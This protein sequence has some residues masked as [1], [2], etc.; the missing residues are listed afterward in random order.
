MGSRSSCVERPDGIARF[1]AKLGTL[2]TRVF[3]RTSRDHCA[4]CCAGWY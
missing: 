3:R 4:D 2:S 1:G